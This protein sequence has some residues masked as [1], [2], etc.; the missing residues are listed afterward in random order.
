MRQTECVSDG[1]LL[2]E[3]LYLCGPEFGLEERA[4]MIVCKA[5]CRLESGGAAL[6]CAHLVETS[7]NATSN[8]ANGYHEL[9]VAYFDGIMN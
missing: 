8:Q 7:Y 9:T 3:R 2:R 4:S 5:L 1:G 6:F